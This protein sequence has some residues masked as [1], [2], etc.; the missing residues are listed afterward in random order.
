VFIPV[1]SKGARHEIS[2]LSLI[3]RGQLVEL[4]SDFEKICEQYLLGELSETECQ[5]VEEAYFADDSLFERFLAVKDDL[6]D[7]YARRN[8]TDNKLKSFEQH[9]LTSKA[10]RQRVEEAR[11]VIQVTSA[12]AVDT[13][14]V[15]TESSELSKSQGPPWWQLFARSHPFVWR[16][17]L[18]AALLLLIFAGSWIVVRQVQDRA[19]KR[20]AEERA[21]NATTQADEKSANGNV[22]Q[23]PAPTSGINT[24]GQRATPSPSPSATTTP[25]IATKPPRPT[26]AQIASLTLLPFSARETGSANTLTLSQE[27]PVVR[28][29][30]VFG[31]AVYYSF[32]VS[33]RTVDGQQV[34]RRGGLKASSNEAGKTVTLTFDSSLLNRQDYIATLRGRVKNGRPQTIADYYFRVQHTAPQSAATPPKQ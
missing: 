34:I 1:W 12:A 10:R 31:N 6:L 29:N 7:A 21:R 19:A 25:E 8:L 32:E 11:D 2:H 30:L 16:T 17:G 26:S 28:L 24:G 23:G 9:Y 3:S 5:Q 20:S 18:V 14:T 22:P 15:Q 33:V 13:P 27:Q 4:Q